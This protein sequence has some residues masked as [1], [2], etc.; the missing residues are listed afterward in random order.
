M[1][2]VEATVSLG[3]IQESINANGK[4]GKIPQREKEKPRY[5]PIGQS[6]IKEKR[7]G[8]SALSFCA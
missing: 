2:Q 3:T 8:A 1:R 4:K 6:F 7:K 5:K